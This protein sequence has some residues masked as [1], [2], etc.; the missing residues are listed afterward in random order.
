[1]N[2]APTLTRR[3]RSIYELLHARHAR[4][5]AAPTLEEICDTLGLRSRGSMHA[6]VSALVAAGLVEPIEGRQRGVRLSEPADTVPTQLPLL[7]TIAAGSPLE[8]SVEAETIEV[9]PRL[10]GSGRCYVLRVSG[11]SMIDDGILDG[12]LVVIEERT[13]VRDGEVVVALVDGTAATLKRLRRAGGSVSLCPAN[14]EMAPIV[15]APE[16][17]RIQGVLVGQMR[18]FHRTHL[19]DAPH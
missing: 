9:P 18:K 4:G 2:G 15:L 19:A 5:E 17:V 3:Q 11:S 13:H 1:V 8:T 12:D 7:G 14:A 10:R 6:Q 16:R